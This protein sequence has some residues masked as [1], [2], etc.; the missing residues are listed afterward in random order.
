M[1]PGESRTD[2]MIGVAKLLITKLKNFVLYY[3]WPD[4]R[5][6]LLPYIGDRLRPIIPCPTGRLFRGTLFPG[7]S[8][9]A[10]IS[11][12]LRDKAIQPSK[13]LKIILALWGFQPFNPGLDPLC[14]PKS[15]PRATIGVGPPERACRHFANSI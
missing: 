3:F 12:S 8:C 5:E 15:L 4:I 1:I 14:G 9:L 13:R 10:T 2:S 11:L 7:T 6:R